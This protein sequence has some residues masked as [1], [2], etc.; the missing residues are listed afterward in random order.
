MILASSLGPRK[1]QVSIA[2]ECA[3]WRVCLDWITSSRMESWERLRG[4]KPDPIHVW[5]ERA[6]RFEIID[7]KPIF[8]D[9]F[10]VNCHETYSVLKTYY[11]YS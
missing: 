6:F 11:I 7:I 1:A 5:D 3:K 4:I 9:I 2:C 10:M 8:N